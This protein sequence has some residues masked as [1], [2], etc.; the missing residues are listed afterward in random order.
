ML[1]IGPF[2]RE[3]LHEW[4]KFVCH[5]KVQ[6]V[7]IHLMSFQAVVAIVISRDICQTN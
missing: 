6:L 7:R 4:L 2:K 5:V 1:L 3:L